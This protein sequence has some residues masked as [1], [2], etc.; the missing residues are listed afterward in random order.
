MN[1]TIADDT[2]KEGNEKFNLVLSSPSGATLPDPVGTATIGAS[3]QPTVSSPTISVGDVVVGEQDGFAEFVVRLSAPST[4]PVSVAFFNLDGTAAGVAYYVAVDDTLTFAPGVMVQTVRV[5]I[6]DD[7]AAEAKESFFFWLS[8]P[9]N[10]AIGRTIALATIIDNDGVPGTPMMAIS[11]PVVDEK[12]GEARFSVTLDRPSNGVVT[13]HYTTQAGSAG[14][15]DF[16]AAS[17][18]LSFAPG[19]TAKTVNVTIADDTL[20]EGNE[21]FN[22][23]LFSPTGATLPDPVG[24]ATIEAS[25]QPTVSSPT[26]SAGDVVVGEADGFAEFVV[27][28]SAPST[29]PVS[30]EFFNRDGT[31]AGGADYVFAHS[32]AFLNTLTFAPGE[33]VQTVR[34]P[35][36]DDGTAEAK[37]SFLFDLS[38]PTNAAIGRTFAL[39]T[40]IDNDGVPGTPMMAISDPVVD[41]K[42]GEASFSVTLDRPSNGV[43]TAHYTTQAGSAGAA[44]FGAA[45]GVLSFAPGETAKTVNVTIADDTL[46]E[47]NEKF[48]LALFSPTGATL[49]DPV[50]TATIG[51]S[52][53]P[54]VSSPTISAGD[55]VV[56]EADGFAEF[57]VR[58]SAPSTLPVSVDFSNGNGTAANG[59]DYVAVNSPA[60]FNTLTFAPGETVQTVRVPIIDD[61]ATEPTEA[62]TLELFNPVNA[63]IVDATATAS[64]VDDDSHFAILHYG[65]SNDTYIVSN[66]NTIIIE[67]ADGGTDLVKSSV[68]FTLPANVENLTLTGA[69][70]STLPATR[71]TMC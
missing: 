7:G 68:S 11:D 67:T 15:A 19:E 46:K 71:S 55:V 59:A 49:P 60:F 20:K 61:T 27:R 16:G 38:G 48:N 30:V 28:L 58:L 29:L 69:A 5:P 47:G 21:K 6:I 12:A 17:G 52:D 44:D 70:R 40:I 13:V 54:T 22:L 41:E 64:I 50:G 56:G 8:N 34:V 62:F 37:E 42:A 33:M 14:A 3:D 24:T 36:I 66:P 1:V 32:A 43:V 45:S 57:V 26:I 53:Q 18:V 23:A 25:D 35:I 65:L 39:A 9:T 4:L 51:A 63:T 2:L 31:T 10:A